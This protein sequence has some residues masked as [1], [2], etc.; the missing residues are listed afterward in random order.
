MAKERLDVT[1]DQEVIIEL[2]KMRGLA[3]R[4]AVVNDLLK[5]Q[6]VKTGE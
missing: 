6:L 4:S 2:D 5:K 3:T 1:V